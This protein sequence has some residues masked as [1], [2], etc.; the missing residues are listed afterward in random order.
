MA[1]DAM[2]EVETPI[3]LGYALAQGHRLIIIQLRITHLHKHF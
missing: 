2:G 1:T 3:P